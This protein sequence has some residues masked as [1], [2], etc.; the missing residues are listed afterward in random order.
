MKYKRIKTEENPLPLIPILLLI[1]GAIAG[2]F[3]VYRPIR[4]MF[5][6][7]KK[8]GKIIPPLGIVAIA[9]ILKKNFGPKTQKVIN[10]G[11]VGLIGYTAVVAM[12]PETEEE[13]A[14]EIGTKTGKE[15]FEQ[16]G[17][18]K[19]TLEEPAAGTAIF[20]RPTFHFTIENLGSATKTF[21]WT[22]EIEGGGRPTGSVTLTPSQ[23]TRVSESEG[24]GLFKSTGRYRVHIALESGGKDI[25]L[26][27]W[28]TFGV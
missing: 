11:S 19:V 2:Y 12:L 21:Y 13:K 16:S 14:K 20:E 25:L 10:Y 17:I 22:L 4:E 26:T 3:F 15:T 18:V 28:W 7:S 24:I 23:A 5:G 6:G 9:Q 8:I 1:G 27:D